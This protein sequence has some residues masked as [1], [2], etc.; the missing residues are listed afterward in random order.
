MAASASRALLWVIAVNWNGQCL[1]VVGDVTHSYSAF[2]EPVQALL[3]HLARS[4]GLV[5]GFTTC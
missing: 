3:H 2:V 4:A 1:M 5:K